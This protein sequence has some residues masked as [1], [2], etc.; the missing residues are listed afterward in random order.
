[1]GR[2][3]GRRLL[4]HRDDRPVQSKLASLP[5]KG[6]GP[7]ESHQG[8]GIGDGA[9]KTPIEHL[10]QRDPMH[11]DHLISAMPEIDLAQATG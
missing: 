8:L 4:S 11:L 6:S 7:V 2:T 5:Q 9:V 10:I 1:M 3:H